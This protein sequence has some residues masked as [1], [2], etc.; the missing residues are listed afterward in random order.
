MDQ[1]VSIIMP[2]YNGEKYIAQ[3]IESVLAQTY[4]NWELIIAD[5]CSTD[6]SVNII[7]SYAEKDSR[8]KLITGEKNSGAAQARNVALLQAKG[9]W[10]AFLDSDDKWLPAKLEKQI[11][12][13]NANGYKFSCTKYAHIDENSKPL[14]K[15]VTSPKVIGKRKMFRYNYLGCLTVMYDAEAIGVLQVNPEIGNGRNDYA[16]W[17]KAV[18]REK[19]YYYDEVLALYR[20]RTSSLSHGK[21]LRLVRTHYDLMRLSEGRSKFV[22]CYYTLKHLF[23]GTL[24]KLFYVKKDKSGAES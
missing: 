12:F 8:I 16:L 22:S 14:N 15:V 4:P 18:K 21:K 19:C 6:N 9:K 11:A 10:I 17:L 20:V 5:D 23:Y 3:T 1:L 24:K 2:N 7:N 13:M